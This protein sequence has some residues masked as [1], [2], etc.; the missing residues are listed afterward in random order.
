MPLAT[1][2]DTEEALTSAD[3]ELVFRRLAQEAFREFIEQA[4][5]ILEPATPFL[6]NW[7]ID[8]MADHLQAMT[9]GTLRRLIINVPPGSAKSLIVSVMWP[10]WHWLHR[11]AD[12]FLTA[13]YTDALSIRDA[14]KSRRLLSSIWYQARWG[15]RFALTGDMN[16][17]SKYENDKT[18]FRL[19]THVGGATGERAR[20]RILDDPHE[21]E[22]AE[23]DQ[24]RES[25]IDWVRTTWAERESDP[26][27]SID[28]VV[29]QRLHERDVSGFLL[30]E[31]GGY[32]H[33]M[34][35][36]EF[37]PSRKFVTTVWPQGDPR[38]EE[39]ELLFPARW[40]AGDVALKKKRLGSY[41]TAGQLQQRPAPDEGGI[42]K[43][44]WWRYW[45]YPNHPLPPVMVK[46]AD[47]HTA[48]ECVELPYHFDAYAQ[49]WDM[50]FK[51]EENNDFVVGGQW[52]KLGVDSYCLDLVRD[53]QDFVGTKR[54]VK[55]FN[56]T[57]NVP[58]PKLVEDKA[59]GPAI[60]SSLREEIPGI[61]MYPVLGGDKMARARAYAPYVE[62]GNVILP[63]PS[64][65]P[66]VP[67]F[68]EECAT[69]P[70]ATHDDQVDMWS[71]VM[72]KLYESEPDVV[73]ITP[74]Y[75]PQ[76]HMAPSPQEPTR[77]AAVQSFRFWMDGLNPTCIIAQMTPER[78]LITILECVQLQNASVEELID[79]KVLPILQ[80]GAYVGIGNQQW[81]DIGPHKRLTATSSAIE[82]KLSTL[83]YERFKTYLEPGE[84]DFFQRVTAIKTILNQT[85]RMFI[86]RRA[87][88]GESKN[89]VHEALLGGYAYKTDE[90]G[91][92]S[93]GQARPFHPL[94]A[95][96]DCLGHG[97]ARCFVRRPVQEQETKE[98]L[99]T[100]QKRASGYAVGGN[101]QPRKR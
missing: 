70:N 7:H 40:D 54:M 4:W 1:L 23:S 27:T 93:Q 64:I 91:G 37:E 17:K 90:K 84:P 47:G 89:L 68:I 99:E 59:N 57:W 6:P 48:I 50:S 14:L 5:H 16:T 96:G 26:R 9:D 86:N 88:Q 49:S 38:T 76:F 3:V 55:A 20:V 60:V 97:L 67:A 31:V 62:A 77:G 82:H 11:P 101:Q 78:G 22:Q 10:A 18:G 28:V 73:P 21:I 39:G 52:A 19:A 65:A 33:L 80:Q 92:V 13:S 66:W 95:V 15:S 83:I 29:M 100:R 63:H 12:R 8:A 87:S 44:H 45:H 69:F 75:H 43:R 32:E 41:G 53:R 25:T 42:L 36:M 24:I 94:T 71:Q 46:T 72:S 58:G 30:D 74:E 79:R 34:I 98:P 61:L 2:D 51:G 56:E 81:R 35:P 85:R